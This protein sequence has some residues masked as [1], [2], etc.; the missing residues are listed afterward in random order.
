MNNKLSF[1]SNN[2]NLVD[3]LKHHQSNKQ[4][5]FVKRDVDVFF[6][7]RIEI[8]QVLPAFKLGSEERVE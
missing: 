7:L 6:P 5:K 4:N 2:F 3:H 8:F 1:T